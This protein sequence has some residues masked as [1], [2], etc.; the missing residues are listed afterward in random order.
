V[1]PVRRDGPITM[2]WARLDMDPWGEDL[3]IE[4]IQTDWLRWLGTWRDRLLRRV[5]RVERADAQRFL[6]ATHRDHARDWDRVVM[7]AVLSFAVRDLGI[8]RIWLHQPHSGAKLKRI[9]QGP[10]PPRSIYTDL[11]RRFGFQ[12]TDRAPDFLYR[13][14]SKA[15]ANLRRSGKPVFWCLDLTTA[16]SAGMR[17][18][19]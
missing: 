17:R 14:R 11:P 15:I 1:Q 9:H 3:L 19:A 13:A 7:L 12:A 2:G 10:L 18:A 16:A 6:D 4:E 5:P 8:R